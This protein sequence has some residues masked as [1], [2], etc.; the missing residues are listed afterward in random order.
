MVDQTILTWAAAVLAVGGALAMIWKLVFP[1][2]NRIKKMMDSLD[3]FIK[4]WAGEDA[5][6]GH[7]RIPGVMERL[8]KIESE[9]RHNGGSSI[10][11][12]VKRIETTQS[13]IL[14]RLEEGNERFEKIEEKLD[15]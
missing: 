8:Q 4:D 14:D 9:L 12:A 10:K 11:D 2:L 7:S 5:R 15:D 13:K 3:M 1:I 6:P